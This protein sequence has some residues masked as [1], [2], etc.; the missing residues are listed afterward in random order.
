MY[1]PLQLAAFATWNATSSIA[2][3]M[4]RYAVWTSLDDDL[5]A[6]H[7]PRNWRVLAKEPTCRALLATEPTWHEL[8]ADD[9]KN[10]S[11]LAANGNDSSLV[12]GA[13][14]AGAVVLQGGRVC[15]QATDGDASSHVQHRFLGT[16]TRCGFEN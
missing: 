16:M 7:V 5:K 12:A 13:C 1:A 2:D 4:E 11:L 15:G 6:D 14:A 8:I 10:N 9:M 3:A